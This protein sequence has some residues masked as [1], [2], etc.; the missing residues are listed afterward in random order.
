MPIAGLCKVSPNIS[1]CGRV[2]AFC[3]FHA[4]IFCIFGGFGGVRNFRYARPCK[5]VLWASIH[6]VR[7]SH[8]G[9]GGSATS[10]PLW[11]RLPGPSILLVVHFRHWSSSRTKLVI[12]ER[13]A[14]HGRSQHPRGITPTSETVPECGNPRGSRV[15]KATTCETLNKTLLCVSV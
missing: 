5:E 13:H 6:D 14:R 2:F 1:I 8:T 7:W 3:A 10:D 9:G 4:F 12:I 11:I 15:L